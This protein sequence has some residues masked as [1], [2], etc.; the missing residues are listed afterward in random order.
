MVQKNRLRLIRLLLLPAALSGPLGLAEPPAEQSFVTWNTFEPDKCASIW[1]IKRFIAPE[2]RILFF[3]PDQ[4]P[5]PGILFDTPDA[6]FRRIHNKSTYET[7]FDHYQPSDARL[8]Y[9]GRL[10]HDMEVNVWARKALPE[11]R[12]VEAELI[13]VLTDTPTD[14]AVE[15]C[16]GYFD[17]LFG[18]IDPK[19]VSGPNP[20]PGTAPR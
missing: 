15:I 5:P 18:R 8:A 19:P 4:A 17:A 2:A 7:L 20:A 3:E 11:T 10:I 16:L 1:L 13:E 14:R 12:R 9:I 6:R